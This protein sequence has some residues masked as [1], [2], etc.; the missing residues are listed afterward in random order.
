MTNLYRNPRLNGVSLRAEFA[1]NQKVVRAH[2][3]TCD[4]SGVYC[5]T[6]IESLISDMGSD[7][8]FYGTWEFVSS[9]SSSSVRAFCPTCISKKTNPSKG[10][11]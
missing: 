10:K 9:E 2:C 7:N 1:G 8:H 11:K 4:N 5:Y 3:F 6:N